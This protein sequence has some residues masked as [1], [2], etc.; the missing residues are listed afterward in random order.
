MIR[1]FPYYALGV[2]IK[3]VFKI[4]IQKAL[5]LYEIPKLFYRPAYYV[6]TILF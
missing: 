6:T 2:H 1:E 5:F 3:H 4:N